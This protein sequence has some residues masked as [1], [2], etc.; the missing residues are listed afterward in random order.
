MGACIIDKFG[1][2]LAVWLFHTWCLIVIFALAH[3]FKNFQHVPKQIQWIAQRILS[4]NKV[5]VGASSMACCFNMLPKNKSYSI[6]T[7]DRFYDEHGAMSHPWSSMLCISLV[8][9]GWIPYISCNNLKLGA[10]V[11]PTEKRL[12]SYQWTC[13]LI[14]ARILQFIYIYF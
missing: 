1:Q 5:F 7:M 13:S 14:N 12:V 11:E 8:L 2:V 9:T 4:Y 10:H 6:Q 3:I